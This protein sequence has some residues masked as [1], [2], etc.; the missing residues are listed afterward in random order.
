MGE[1]KLNMS[2]SEQ[3]HRRLLPYLD[4]VEPGTLYV[5]IGSERGEGSTLWLA[6]QALARN[7]VLH[8]VDVDGHSQQRHS[9]E[10]V[11]HQFYQSV[12]A[13][14]WPDSNCIEEL[15]QH[16]QKKLDKFISNLKLM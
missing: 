1:T 13:P 9:I 15:P 12:R 2:T 10:P 8:T 11:W 6:D 14:G 16:I 3:K 5:E 4:S 7:T